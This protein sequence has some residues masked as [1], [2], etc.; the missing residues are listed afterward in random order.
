MAARDVVE[1]AI[2]ISAGAAK[3]EVAALSKEVGGLGT[4][5]KAASATANTLDTSLKGVGAGAGRA[6]EGLEGV[7]AALSLVSPEAANLVRG[8]GMATSGLKG[9]AS[10]GGGLIGVLGPVAVAVAAFAAVWAKLSN[11]LDKANAKLKESAKIAR[12]A[13]DVFAPDATVSGRASGPMAGQAKFLETQADVERAAI[14]AAREEIARLQTP[15]SFY[16]GNREA[17]IGKLQGV[18]SGAATRLAGIE[19]ALAGIDAKVA[20]GAAEGAEKGAEKGSERGSFRGTAAAASGEPAPTGAVIT[21]ADPTG[22]V[23]ISRV[24][25]IG[26]GMSIVEQPRAAVITEEEPVPWLKR[27]GTKAALGAAGGLVQGDVSGLLSMAGPVGAGIGGLANIGQ[28]GAG[29]VRDQLE[30]FTDA[31]VAGLEALPEILVEVI[32]D[33]IEGLIT[34]LIPALVGTFPELSKAIAI[35]LP[36]A[37]AK[38]IVDALA[39]VIPGG[40]AST[41]ALGK[42]ANTLLDH[43]TFGGSLAADVGV[44]RGSR[45]IGGLIDRTGY[46]MMH[47]GEQVIP[48]H[49][50]GSGTASR[51]QGGG[52]GATVIVQG[53]VFG[54]LDTFSRDL[55][56]HLGYGGPGRSTVLGR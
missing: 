34:D 47:S 30:G 19:R 28:M 37:L 5:A 52:G 55:D 56:Q 43:L 14:G 22:A 18:E 49:G 21:N 40:G 27:D 15:G 44:G 46:Y 2:K 3:A 10:V 17:E 50:A 7:A 54:S 38:A 45:A 53:S 25:D 42:G 48:A 6:K 31:V 16:L 39:S 4:Q 32:P 23:T 36:I 9:L 33:F 51:S 26:G 13:Q 20:K 29:G 12:E 35:D 24:G 11:D 8:V 1:V 41:G